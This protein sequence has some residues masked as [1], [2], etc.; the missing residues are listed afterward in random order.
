MYGARA[1]AE[2]DQQRSPPPVTIR[3]PAEPHGA[4][5]LL[6]TGREHPS[7]AG[8]FR[9]PRSSVG[10]AL[11]VLALVAAAVTLPDRWKPPGPESNG[12]VAVSAE[13]AG[14]RSSY[15]P[16]SATA[17]ITLAVRLR[18]DGPRDVTVFTGELAGFHQQQDD[19]VLP[20]GGHGR[21]LLSGTVSCP[22]RALAAGASEGRL[23]LQVRAP[24]GSQRIEV[25]IAPPLTGPVLSEACGF[26]AAAQRVSVDVASAAREGASLHLT[27][28]VRSRS[29]HPVQAQAVAMAP[30][31][32]VSALGRAALDLPVPERGSSSEARVDVRATVTDCVVAVR[33]VKAGRSSVTVALTDAQLQVFARSARYE[34]SLLR[35]LVEDACPS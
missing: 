28:V 10:P 3:N 11:V 13:V 6:D 26:G 18:N 16:T 17:G 2:D 35:S 30:G 9:L 7:R 29:L 15:D 24:A 4:A 14:T 22:S 27:L 32:T 23:V 33:S 12:E 34:P 31:L 25:P 19:L 20:A 21:L 8:G 5:E 1:P